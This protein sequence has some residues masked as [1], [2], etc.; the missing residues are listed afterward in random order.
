MA[1]GDEETNWVLNLDVT[2]ALE[3]LS[4][5]SD[6]LTA[7]T[8]GEGLESLM[9]AFTSAGIALGVVAGAV[10]A[11]KEAMDLTFD[12]EQIE[13][14]NAQ[15][16]I[17]TE[18]AGIAGD[19]LKSGLQEASG[20][21]IDDTT[22]MKDANKAI[23]EL[24]SNAQQLD[25]VMTVARQASAV[26]G[27]DISQ[28]FEQI[29]QAI[30]SGSTRQL[31]SMGIIIDQQKAYSDFAKSI[32]VAT[33]E[34]SKEG[35][36]H[37]ILNAVLE[38]SKTAFAGIDPN[39]KEATNA[40]QAFKATITDLK[41]IIVVAFEKVAGPTLTNFFNNLRGWTSEA[42]TYLSAN[43]GTGVEQ[44]AAKTKTLEASL[45]SLKGKLVDLEFNTGKEG[46]LDKWFGPS[47]EEKIK[48]ITADIAATESQLNALK[49][50][51]ATKQIATDNK[52]QKN[53]D[54][55][56]AKREADLKKFQD[57]IDKLRS[58]NLANELKAATTVAAPLAW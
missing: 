50:Q 1:G 47:K 58:Q 55:N 29:T 7:A 26:S 4:T 18:K 57:E 27:G 33:N 10:Y 56:T 2:D 12:G 20:G 39:M 43:F 35:Q 51:S 15:F 37:A 23:V 45:Q 25:Q 34:L 17:L 5:F 13:A 6:G 44:T 40:F 30:A 14:I 38:Q 21:L 22:L 19:A 9:T 48:K 11:V 54:V 28:N 32:G 16:D 3:S 49:E 24:G 52:V 8:N 42:K 41:D 36:Q 46:I 53:N 31:R